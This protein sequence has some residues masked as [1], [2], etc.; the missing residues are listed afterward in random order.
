M[1]V[2]WEAAPCAE[3]DALVPVVVLDIGLREV[4]VPLEHAGTVDLFDAN[5]NR[6]P[7]Q[8]NRPALVHDG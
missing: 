5:D 3:G 2:R 1:G 7:G 6:L 4:D 8:P